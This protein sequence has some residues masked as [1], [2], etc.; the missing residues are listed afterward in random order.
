[1]EWTPPTPDVA[2]CGDDRNPAMPKRRPP[3]QEMRLLEE[4]YDWYCGKPP[5]A[6]NP[7]DA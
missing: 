5:V 1:M 4:W 3:T 7:E 6:I 2:A